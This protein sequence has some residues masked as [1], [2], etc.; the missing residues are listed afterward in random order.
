MTFEEAAQWKQEYDR[1]STSGNHYLVGLK[2]DLD[3]SRAVSIQEAKVYLE[4]L[5]FM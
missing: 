4:L 1:Y 5:R 3:S 2:S